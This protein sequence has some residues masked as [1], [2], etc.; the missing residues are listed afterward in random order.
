MTGANPVEATQSWGTLPT[1]R[2]RRS[3]AITANYY[4]KPNPGQLSTIFTRIA[5]DL[6]RP[7][8]RL[9]DDNTT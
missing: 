1:T 7:A 4:D 3:Q 8:A 5:A 2:S 6:S 9:I